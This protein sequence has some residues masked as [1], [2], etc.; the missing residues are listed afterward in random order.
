MNPIPLRHQCAVYGLGLFS[1]SMFFMSVVI[2]PLWVHHF[3]LSPFVLGLVLGCRPILPLFL[4]IHAGVMMDRLGARRVMIFFA[5]IGMVVPLI[6][7]FAPWVWAIVILQLLSGLADSMGW[8]GAQILVGQLFKARTA[9]AARLGFIIRFGHLVGPP[10]VGAAWDFWGPWGAFPLVA[11]W[12]IG[13]LVSS[14]MLPVSHNQ[15]DSTG[16]TL[17]PRFRLRDILPNPSDYIDAFRLLAAPAVALTVFIGL[18]T[19]V[20]NS[21]QATF[22][23]VWLEQIGIPGTL[24]GILVSVSAMAAGFGSLIATRLTRYI[25]PFWLLFI[26]VWTAILLISITP[27]LGTYVVLMIV[28]SLRSCCNGI[29]QPLVITLMLRA[30]GETSHGRAIGLRGTANRVAS[31]A[32]PVGMGALAEW[33][34]IEAS[35]YVIGAISSAIMLFLAWQLSRHPEVHEITRER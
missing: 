18:M 12:G 7:P 16:A 34:G 6:F 9:L 13:V 3:K 17:R 32:A 11:F 19:H 31:I 27:L 15:M 22:Y 14:L 29:H 8:L 10:M 20:G 23:I 28:L 26:V 2:V 24:I 4:S 1:T 25:K 21:V 33:I 5:L 30:A 35:F